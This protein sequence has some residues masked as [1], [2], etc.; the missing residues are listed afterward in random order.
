MQKIWK[1][2]PANPVLQA[3]LAEALKLH[4]LL[5]Q[6]LSNRGI[7]TI[8]AAEDFLKAD[9]SCLHDP[10]DLEDM[11]RVVER[12]KKAARKK[13]KVLI[14]SDFDVDGVTSCA[15]VKLLM[16][17]FGIDAITYIPHRVNEGY[18]ISTKAIKLAKEKKVSLFISLDC[19]ITDYE[20][21]KAIKEAGIDAVVIDHH[22]PIKDTL[23]P[24]YGIINPKKSSCAYPFEDL[25]SVGLAYKLA[26]ALCDEGFKEHL[27]L[28][29]LGTVADVMSLRGENRIL[30]KEGLKEI[31]AT[32]RIGLKALI[33]AC[34][35]QKKKIM[36]GFIS[37]ALGPRINASGRID[38]AEKAL[39]LLLSSDFEEAKKLATDLNSYNRQRQK[40]QTDMFNQ[41][42]N[43]VEREVNF[44]EHFVIVLSQKDWHLGV[45]G[46][47]ASKIADRF[48]RPT[49]IISVDDKQVG[50]GSARSIEQ[51]HIFDAISQCSDT[52]LGFGGH[53]YAAGIS[54]QEKRI[55]AFRSAINKIAREALSQEE[56]FPALKIDAQVPLQ[57]LSL[58]IAYA[59]DDLAP[60]GIGN[61]HPVFC[62]RNLMV[63]SEPT[64]VGRDTI[65]FWV[66]DGKRTTQVVG[67]GM[68]ETFDMIRHAENIDIA[69][70]VSIDSW[71]AEPQIQLE[72][73]DV[74]VA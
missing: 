62:S 40:I 17:K 7:N 20:E 13:E 4:P 18:G 55:D 45:L 22:K 58:D 69:Y 37:Y 6:V 67:F 56:L 2:A 50:K 60:F 11:E 29:A 14:C 28:V 16:Q 71:H 53:K 1:I 35:L 66:T 33:D 57:M 64:I 68:G 54:V 15:V 30:V 73:K 49:I 70:A 27:D 52:L 46:I 10:F 44:K 65:K 48:Y 47:V 43:L 21:L 72:L 51:F 24:A 59:I 34:G 36:P 39:S 61:P 63:K 12:I 42:L 38:S 41:A 26:Q 3:R 31:N 19:G 9:I 23:P 25:A 74:R 32:K 5:S 8:A